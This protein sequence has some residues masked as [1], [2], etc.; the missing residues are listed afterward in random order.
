MPPI[1]LLLVEDDPAQGELLAADL[2]D[3]GYDVLGPAPTVAEARQLFEQ[4]P[5][6]LL[7]DIGLKGEQLDGIELAAE[8]L[9]VR[10]TP[11]IFLTSFEDADTFRRARNVGP[12]AY[13]VKPP[14]PAQVQRAIELALEQFARQQRSLLLAADLGA[15]DSASGPAADE[16]VLALGGVLS[17]RDCLFVR[18][19]GR[20]LKIP[21]DEILWMAADEKYSTLHTA[22]ARHSLRMPLRELA[23]EVAPERFVQIHRSYVVQARCI[24][25]IDPAL[26]T[27]TVAGEE[28]PLGRTYKEN[29]LRHLRL[30]G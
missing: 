6:L 10:P 4:L 15:T 27:V 16:P 13:L 18:E 3:L 24:E 2:A 12:A 23:A 26:S 28:L 29:L 25:A 14:E 20:L 19:R 21:L 5:D 1:R 9:R 17:L 8:L 30:V 7:L 11:L 22:R